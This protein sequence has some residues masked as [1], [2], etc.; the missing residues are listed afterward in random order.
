MYKSKRIIVVDDEQIMLSTLKML[1]NIEGFTNVEYFES[2]KS[3][4]K[5][6]R[7]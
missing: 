1:L 7:K 4:L 5:Y 6:K 3:T 2:A